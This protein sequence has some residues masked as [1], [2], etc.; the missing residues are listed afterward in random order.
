VT[1]DGSPYFFGIP[2]TFSENGGLVSPSSGN[3]KLVQVRTSVGGDGF[4][5]YVVLFC[6]GK[7]VSVCCL[8]FEG[9]VA[10]CAGSTQRRLT[11]RQ[12]AG[13]ST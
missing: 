2:P 3:L 9:V 8:C 13:E 1:V 10:R 5:A 11:G 4:G 7:R 12:A 6:V